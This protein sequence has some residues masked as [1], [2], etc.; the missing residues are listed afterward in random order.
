MSEPSKVVLAAEDEETDRL[1]L[2]LA[3]ERA[4]VSCPLVMV[5]DGQEAIDY[6][7]GK[8]PYQE[9]LVYPVPGLLL[10]DLKMPRL[11]GFDVLE[12]LALN[13][14]F[15][16]LPAIVFSSSSHESD[17]QKARLLGAKDYMVK[18]PSLSHL[19]SAIKSLCDRWLACGPNGAGKGEG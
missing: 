17:I 14:E 13:R 2:K 6:L 7:A 11:T 5:R 4:Q 9:R 3:F 15:R 16:N 19:V 12:W 8:P 1:I 18:T 10:L